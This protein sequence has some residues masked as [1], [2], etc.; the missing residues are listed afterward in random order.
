MK[1]LKLT[2]SAF[3]PYPGEETIDFANLNDKNIFLITGPTGAGKTTI[4]DAISYALFGEASGSSR[5][6][7]SLR[8]H[9][10]ASN[11][12]TY[13]EMEFELRG[14]C[15]RVKRNPKQE[16]KKLRGEGLT[17]RESDAEL[18][19]PDGK[20][21]T[22]I[23]NVDDKITSLLGINKNQFRQ[24]VMLPQGEFRKLLEAESK[25]REVIF[26]KIFGTEAF[27][28]IQLKLDNLQ[29]S[30][31][32]RVEEG[33]TRRDTHVKHIQPGED[34]ILTKLI[35]AQYLNIPDIINSTNG[36]ILKDEEESKLI[37]GIIKKV[38]NEQELLNKEIINGEAV[39]KKLLEKQQ[40]ENLYELELSKEQDYADKQ[41]TLEK[42]RKAMHVKLV[43]DT[44]ND[45]NDNLNLRKKQY[46]EAEVSLVKAE[47]NMKLL[48]E[49]LKIEEGKEEQRKNLVQQIGSL[50][51]KEQKVRTY[52]EKS[53]AINH[54][55]EELKRK[56][57]NLEQYKV[58]LAKEKTDLS[59]ANEKYNYINGCE[60]EKLKL[61]SMKNE[62]NL[63]IEKLREL[64]GKT[65][66]Y[67]N[68]VK[69]HW[70][71]ANAY[72]AFEVDYIACKNK[73]EGLQTRFLKE[74]AGI[75][76]K[77]L[78]DGTECPVCGS[79]HH[80]KP[81]E[82]LGDA[83]TEEEVNEAK[84]F[85]DNMEQENRKKLLFLSELK[86][87][88]DSSLNELN[89]TK[90]KFKSDLGESIISMNE[91]E[92]IIYINE[93]GPKLKN[94]TDELQLQIQKL[95]EAVNQKPAV[96]MLIE[97]LQDSIT[98]I[99]N[100]LPKLEEDYTEFYGRVTSELEQLKSLEQEI[101]EEIRSISKLAIKIKQL[102][103]ELVTSEDMFKKST[104]D[105]NNA[106]NFYSSI[107][108]EKDARCENLKGA[109]TEVELW[110]NNLLKKIKDSGFETYE[111]YSL[112]KMN[113][114]E[115]DNLDKV[116]VEYY[117]KLHT[118]KE[119]LQKL[120]EETYGL[121]YID[122]E[123]LL[124]ALE[125]LKHEE[126]TLFEKKE[127]LFSRIKNN[128]LVV[129]EINKIN[130]LIGEDEQKYGIVSDISKAANGFNDERITFERYVLAAYFDEIISAAN[131]RLSK[132]AA[133]RFVLKRKEEKG[134]GQRQEGL[135]L[136]V[137]DNY[138]G[139]ARHVKTLSG[140]ESF[141][142]S[143]ALAL[144]LADVVQSYAGGISLD[145]MFVDEGFGTLDP[146]SLDHA[147]QCLID[148]QKGGRLVGII[149]HVPELK[150]R[151]DVRLEITPAKEGSK[152]RFV[153]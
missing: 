28:T 22:Q 136:E 114:R 96:T 76:A 77:T 68:N 33:K 132:M 58:S 107:K 105:F 17:I 112:V 7:D 88:I 103:N 95:D 51:E 138:T 21:I 65:R 32:K 75:L 52:E 74:Q 60:T 127:N 150:E 36:L 48:E 43:E 30:Y 130:S 89:E 129:N 34:E 149:S 83:P 144:G 10:A 147:I 124:K 126:N 115:I 78:S 24:I 9:F 15:Y 109:E 44:L 102:N 152:A 73:F 90:E 128:K 19:L 70:E 37:N 143:L 63:L 14:E 122:I 71:E 119:G 86:G 79:I 93:K 101:P 72:K 26:R 42:A 140:G 121:S 40:Q 145:T 45:R 123:I 148:L 4:F 98:S 29:K 94:K 16:A 6:N 134:K 82:L 151:I 100:Q 62:N 55:Q 84:I 85:Y 3:G 38:K 111:D 142:A 141:K 35:N 31:Y 67:K 18:Q 139:R 87:R 66:Q 27:Q 118:A 108:A 135:E 116:I 125:Q 110:R 11:T 5:D 8:S 104:E 25:E 81:A 53:S 46:S 113:E 54:L 99:E 23:K 69:Q 106:K 64:R 50:K 80:P 91:D 59:K 97:R 20:L 56:Q 49:K 117:K 1:P 2:M 133:G 57:S 131:L 39:N 13:I 137:F 61:E 41:K 146:E 120:S 12:F 153:M 92:I 47:E